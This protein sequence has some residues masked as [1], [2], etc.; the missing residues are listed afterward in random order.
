M[1]DECANALCGDNAN[2]DDIAMLPLPKLPSPLFLMM[3]RM[4]VDSNEKPT[5]NDDNLNVL[6]FSRG[7]NSEKL[8][9]GF[10]VDLHP[11]H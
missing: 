7:T 11:F 4:Q 9:V 6:I 3:M 5:N 1:T 2:D 8:F 10:A